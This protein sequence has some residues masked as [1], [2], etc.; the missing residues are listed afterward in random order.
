MGSVE[1]EDS[2]KKIE[3]QV[4]RELKILRLCSCPYIV[5]FYGA[6][7]ED[8]GINIMME[9]MDFGTLESLY[10][11]N[12]PI[13]ETYVSVFTLQ[14]LQGLIYLYEQHKIVHRGMFTPKPNY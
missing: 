11:K 14:L 4:I 7:L 6:F 10:Q 9:F 1:S 12:G 8:V 5:A 3:K 2:Q 13:P